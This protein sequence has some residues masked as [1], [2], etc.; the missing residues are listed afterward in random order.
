MKRSSISCDVADASWH[1]MHEKPFGPVVK[2][3]TLVML[4]SIRTNLPISQ[5]VTHSIRT[6]HDSCAPCVVI[7]SCKTCLVHDKS[8][9]G[10]VLLTRTG[11]RSASVGDDAGC[12]GQADSVL[13]LQVWKA[14]TAT[15]SEPPKLVSSR[16]ARFRTQSNR[17]SSQPVSTTARWLST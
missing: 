15:P 3:M 8:F 12:T 2:V 13:L 9:Y 4:S 14:K 1:R 7:A 6:C 5:H 17:S 10:S 11:L 16:R